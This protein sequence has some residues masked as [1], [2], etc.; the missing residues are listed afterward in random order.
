MTGWATLARERADLLEDQILDLRA[1]GADKEKLDILHEKLA[2]VRM[3]HI[4]AQDRLA[5]LTGSAINESWSELHR[6]EERIDDLTPEAHVDDLVQDAERHVEYAIPGKRAVELKRKLAV[7]ITAADR[8]KAAVAAIHE[9]HGAAEERH[10]SERNQQRG[11]LYIAAGFFAVAVVAIVVQALL[12]AADRIIPLPSNGVTMDGWAL[13]ALVMLFGMLGG[14]LSALASLY[15]T[16]KKL[17]NTL[18]FDPR[19]ALC[20]VKVMTGLWTAV[21]GVL[22]VATGAIVGIYTS[23]ASVLLL[24]FLF[25]YAQQAVTRFIDRKVADIIGTEKS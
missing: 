17:T 14:A 3:H 8:K 18:W 23:L 20:L 15:M 6:L 7:Q 12:P 10:E 13:L 9:A 2:E 1:A 22:A 4:D 16:G 25:G 11:I 5:W 24:A 19:P 21:L